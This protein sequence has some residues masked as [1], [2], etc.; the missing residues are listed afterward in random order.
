MRQGEVSFES[1]VFLFINMTLVLI[2]L[3]SIVVYV[4]KYLTVNDDIT[5]SETEVLM[6]SLLMNPDGPTKY[7]HDTMRL[8]PGTVDPDF[9][10][11]G[12]EILEKIFSMGKM[13]PYFA[14]KIS[15]YETDGRPFQQNGRTV[16][17]VYYLRDKY[18]I[19]VETARMKYRIM[20]S[21]RGPGSVLE[22]KKKYLVNIAGA[23]K[24]RTA[25]MEVSIV[26]LR[27]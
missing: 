26:M 20:N 9:F 7:D 16:E 1:S 25:I 5:E 19:W 12:D 22:S 10:S 24:A 11:D 17:P 3:F 13:E 14:M 23:E 4:Q 2:V 27:S 21:F 18:D 15:L 8:F 6:Y